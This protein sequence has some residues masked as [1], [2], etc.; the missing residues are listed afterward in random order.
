MFSQ[1]KSSPVAS[2]VSR[3]TF[4]LLV[5]DFLVVAILAETG[6][7]ILKKLSVTD[8]VGS[9]ETQINWHSIHIKLSF[10]KP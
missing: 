1:S 6:L 2:K 5:D 4:A 9:L 8:Q 3:F 10:L 7:E